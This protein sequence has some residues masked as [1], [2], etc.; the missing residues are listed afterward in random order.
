MKL[1]RFTFRT[2][3]EAKAFRQGIEFVNDSAVE[4][5]GIEERATEELGLPE[6]TVV[7]RDEDGEDE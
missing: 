7:V 2:E 3:G 5:V 6:F 4:V 1:H